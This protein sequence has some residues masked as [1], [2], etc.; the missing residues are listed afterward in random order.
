MKEIMKTLE[1]STI[2]EHFLKF[3]MYQPAQ[4]RKSPVP[5][6]LIDIPGRLEIDLKQIID[7]AIVLDNECGIP[8]E[9]GYLMVKEKSGRK[10]ST[11]SNESDANSVRD[12]LI[13]K[14]TYMI[15][16]LNYVHNYDYF[17]GLETS[18]PED[19]ARNLISN[20]RGEIPRNAV[21]SWIINLDAQINYRIDPAACESLVL[22]R[23]GKS[24]ENQIEKRISTAVRN[25]SDSKFRCLECQKLFKA[26]EFVRKHVRTKHPSVVEEECESVSF[27]NNFCCDMYKID[28]SK[29]APMRR[30]SGNLDSRLEGRSSHNQ[31][32]REPPQG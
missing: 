9:K 31:T 23:G 4:P 16:Y 19:H 17:S 28:T 22:K 25:E 18:S 2:R 30:N 6:D 10:L 15:E 1:N 3:S 29:P 14:L 32:R 12:E 24:M 21:D 26:D 27:F 13:G 7:L 20:R 8:S 5:K 11:D